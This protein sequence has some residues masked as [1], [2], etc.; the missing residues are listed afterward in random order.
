MASARFDV[1]GRADGPAGRDQLLLMLRSLLA[2][3]FKLTAH[4]EMKDL[5]IYALTVGKNG[6]KFH[7]LKPADA[8]CFPLCAG[9]VKTNHMRYKDLPS[10]AAYLTRLGTWPGE[11]GRPVIDKTGLRGDFDIDLDIAK[12]MEAIGDS[13]GAPP[14][15]ASIYDST[16]SF[17][18]DQLGLKLE[19]RRAPVDVLIID[20]AQK[21][22]EN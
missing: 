1:E 18:E 11:P 16:V 7:A 14:T 20:H 15:N 3:R 4:R 21:P 13:G 6:P 2:E 19:A 17:V 22:S 12:I 5:P 9:A 10:L 8:A